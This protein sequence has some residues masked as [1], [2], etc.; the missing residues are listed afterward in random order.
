MSYNALYDDKSAYE[1]ALENGYLGTVTHWLASLKELN[2][3]D[4]TTYRQDTTAVVE[5]NQLDI[6]LVPTN[7]LQVVWPKV[8]HMIDS[9]MK[10][11]KG[12]INTDQIKVYLA[13]GEYQLLVFL[14]GKTIIAAVVIEWIN[15]PNARVMFINAMGGKTN[16][17]C[18][19]KMFEWAKQNG[20]TSVRGAAHESVARLWKMKFGFETIY[21]LVE[22]KL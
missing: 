1:T 20:A 15:Y 3:D 8:S 2:M 7:Y 11:A 13:T 16:K 5:S 4:V 14:E 17:T 12:E 21:Y 9:A 18:A 22:K 10:H 19:D 6:D